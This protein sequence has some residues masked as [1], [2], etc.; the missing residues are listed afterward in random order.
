MGHPA[1]RPPGAT[2][3]RPRMQGYWYRQGLNPRVAAWLRSRWNA[4]KWAD[5]AIEGW[6]WGNCKCGPVRLKIGPCPPRLGVIL[7]YRL[8]RSYYSHREGVSY[9][10]EDNLNS[11]RFVSWFPPI[12][13]TNSYLSKRITEIKNY[14]V[15]SHA[16]T[17]EAFLTQ[18]PAN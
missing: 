2:G 7:Y 12:N 6:R 11:F 8:R 1:I 10:K 15:S 13:Y 5:H 16:T 18:T 3:C 4:G 9:G 17:L 14:Q